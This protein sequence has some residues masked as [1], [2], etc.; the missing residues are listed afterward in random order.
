MQNIMN[1]VGGALAIALAWWAQ[2]MYRKYAGT[3]SIQIVKLLNGKYGCRY[4]C[5]LMPSRW[6]RSWCKEI[7]QSETPRDAVN[8]LREHLADKGVAFSSE[9]SV[10]CVGFSPDGDLL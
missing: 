1:S 6:H 7:R 5:G 2:V 3:V 10:E 9:G 8:L 4:R